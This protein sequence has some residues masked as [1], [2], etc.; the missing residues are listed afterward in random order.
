MAGSGQDLTWGVTNAFDSRCWRKS[1]SVHEYSKASRH[2]SDKETSWTQVGNVSTR[3]ILPDGVTTATQFLFPWNLSN[4]KWELNLMT[5]KRKTEL[6]I[7]TKRKLFVY[8]LLSSWVVRGTRQV[9]YFGHKQL[10]ENC[11]I[12]LRGAA[13]EFAHNSCKGGFRVIRYT[14]QHA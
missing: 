14:L 13:S 11:R 5:S 2:T 9:Q 10:H 7:S 12:K 8:R 6:K 4:P 1:R 3:A